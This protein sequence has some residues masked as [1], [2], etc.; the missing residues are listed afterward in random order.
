MSDKLYE[1][2]DW[3]E[4]ETIVYSEESEPRRILGPRVTE[5]G[6]LTSAFC[7]VLCRQGSC[8]QKKKQTHDMVM[9]DEAGFFRCLDTWK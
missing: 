3:P 8:S 4:I 6:I 7:P 2:M 5:D 9:E 1:L